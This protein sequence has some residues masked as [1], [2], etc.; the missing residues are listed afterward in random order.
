[1]RSSLKLTLGLLMISVGAWASVFNT[2]VSYSTGDQPIRLCLADFDGDGHIDAAVTRA[3]FG[4]L[5]DPDPDAG[6][7]ILMNNGDGTFADP[8]DYS[9]GDG[10]F[11]ICAADFNND[12]HIDLAVVDYYFTMAEEI[13]GGVPT[14]ILIFLN[15]GEGGFTNTSTCQATGMHCRSICAADFDGDGYNDLAAVSYSDNIVSVLINSGTG[16]FSVDDDYATGPSPNWVCAGHLNGDSYCDLVVSSDDAGTVTVYTNG[17]S[18][19]FAVGGNYDVGANPYNVCLVDVDNDGHKDLA[20]AAQTID[21]I[22]VLKNNGDAT[23]ADAAYYLVPMMPVSLCAADFDNDGYADLAVTCHN[24]NTISTLDNF[25][26]GTFDAAVDYDVGTFPISVRA[27]DLDGDGDNDLAVANKNSGD[28]S[29]LINSCIQSGVDDGLALEDLPDQFQLGR[30]YP[31]PFNPEINIEF[32]LPSRAHVD[33]KIY[34][35]N[36]QLVRQLL[37]EELPAGV[38]VAQ[39]DSRSDSGN[40]VATGIYLCRFKANGFVGMKKMVLLK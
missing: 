2:P 39:W 4:L 24:L 36:G 12:G 3:D 37:S 33:L 27:A 18:G 10:P 29:V 5:P 1:M 21:R 11:A 28:L 20:V 30:V 25:G 19:T 31:N 17:G 22:S 14:D 6:L 15:D 23:F 8:V 26:D 16:T 7:S 38:H 9:A 35:I 32:A 13:S 40:K 34:N